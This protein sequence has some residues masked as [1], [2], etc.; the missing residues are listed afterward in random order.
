MKILFIVSRPLEMNSSASLRNVNTIN[1]LAGEGHEVTVLS[2]FLSREHPAFSEIQLD[3]SVE[4][5]RVNLGMGKALSAKAGRNR[6]LKKIKYIIYK[7]QKKKNLY[8]SWKSMVNRPEVAQMDISKYDLLISSSDPKSSH[9]VAEKVRAESSIPWIQ[10]W[11]DPFTGDITSLNKDENRKAREEKRFFRAASKVLF[12][13]E[14]T[15]A[16]MKE[17]YPEAADKMDFMPRPYSEKK[18][19][20]SRI[21]KGARLHLSYCG[22][23]NSDVRNILPFFQAV[24]LTGDYLK[25]CGRSDLHLVGDEKI[26][27]FPRV[28]QETVDKIEDEADVLIHLSNLGGTQI[29]GKIYNYSATNKPILFILDGNEEMLLGVFSKYNRFLFCKNDVNEIVEKLEIIRNLEYPERLEPVDAFYVKNVM[30][31]LLKTAET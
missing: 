25:L 26:Q 28:P 21:K 16:E 19:M 20:K 10:I 1:G 22:D 11:G 7:K 27:I 29:P 31:S 18:I 14:A 15:C 17:R 8:D 9:L 13:S 5:I 30:R 23:Y 3:S 2:T 12:L 4:V 6:F 24:Q